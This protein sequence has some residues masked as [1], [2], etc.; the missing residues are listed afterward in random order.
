MKVGIDLQALAGQK[1]G[2]GY[3]LSYLLPELKESPGINWVF[4]DKIKKE[5]NT[6]KRILWDQLG[7]PLVS[8]FKTLDLLFVPAF[9]CPL[10]YGGKKVAVVHDL[11]GKIF[12]QNFSS[13]AKI[14]WSQLLPYSFKKATHLIAISE[15]TKKDLIKYLK[16]SEEKISVI[17]LAANPIYQSVK[18]INKAAQILKKYNIHSPFIL[19]VGTVE[20]RKNY[21]RLIQAFAS[22]KRKDELLVIV[23]RFGWRWQASIDLVKRLRLEEKVLFL[24]YL[25]EKDLLYLYNTCLFFIFPSLYEGF[26][27]PV[28]EAMNCGAPVVV[29]NTSSL[30]EVV[31]E[32]GLYI[33]PYDVGDIKEKIEMLLNSE[34]LQAELKE[35]SLRQAKKFSWRKTAQET[36]GV[37]KEVLC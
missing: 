4:I 13:S 17:Y 11:V 23:G 36:A 16:I 7:L 26:G 21:D 35:K 28:L 34:S 22:A 3:Y 8:M 19:S 20:P 2:F 37:F 24:N 6:P 15:N 30:P 5:L 31:E 18:D 14:Y 10:F 32:A 12:A 1:T 25:P 29:S 9:S 27:L 33:D